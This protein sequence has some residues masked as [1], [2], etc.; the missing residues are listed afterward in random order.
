M[1]QMDEVR[2]SSIVDDALNTTLREKLPDGGA[3]L[4]SAQ[5]EAGLDGEAAIS[6]RLAQLGNAGEVL[7]DDLER[8]VSR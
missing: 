6:H 1:Q 4:Y 3:G 5:D 8:L 7:I 2:V